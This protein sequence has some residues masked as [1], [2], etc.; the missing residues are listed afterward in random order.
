MKLDGYRIGE[1]LVHDQHVVICR[2]TR[3]DDDTRVT[4]KYCSREYPRP[5]EMRR[6]HFEFQLLEKLSDAAVVRAVALERTQVGPVLVLEDA[7][8]LGLAEAAGRTLPL[9]TF[10][11]L[12]KG[13]IAA[14]ESVHTRQVIHKNVQPSSLSF[15]ADS[16]SVKLLAFQFA[17]QLTHERQEV[18]AA[19]ALEGALPY[20]SPEQTGRMN[21]TL[22]YRSDYYSL[23]VTFYQLLTGGLPFD[24]PDAMSWV[25]C[26]ISRLAPLA[27]ERRR[28]VPVLLARIIDKLM[29]KDP[30]DRYQSCHGILGDL[31]TCEQN[32]ERISEFADMP[33][34]AHDVSNR[35]ALAQGLVGR[36]EEQ[37]LLMAAFEAARQGAARVLFVG[38]YSG[39]GKSSLIREVHRPIAANR[40]Y[41]AEGKFDQLQRGVPYAAVAQALRGLVQQLLGE[42]EASVVRWRE[43]VGETLSGV[44]GVLTPLVPEL[45]KL[46]GPQ[47]PAPAL[48]PLEAHH[49]FKSALSRFVQA[50]AGASHPVVL[51]LDDLQWADASTVDWLVELVATRE[52][53]HLLVLGA[54]RDN[55][56][57]AGH[58]L[59]NALAEMERRNPSRVARLGLGPLELTDTLALISRA[60]R[61]TPQECEPLARE[62]QRKTQGNPFFVTELLG[63]LQRAG[64][65]SV[66]PS[67]GR[68]HW[69]L[70]AVRTFAASDSAID[71]M[72]S[73]L[74]QLPAETNEVLRLAA[75]LGGEFT[76]Q[77]IASLVRCSVGEAAARLWPALQHDLIVPMG[78][79]YRLAHVVENSIQ[80]PAPE[81]RYRFQHDRVQ[82]AAYSL[83]PDVERA[84]LHLRIGRRLLAEQADPKQPTDLF[85][86]VS[87]LN[88]GRSLIQ[89]RAERKALADLNRR[90]GDRAFSGTA[91]DSA[92]DYHEFALGCLSPAE[93]A[94]QPAAHFEVAA[95]RVYSVLMAGD[96]QRA[97]EL[98]RELLGIAP[99]PTDR[100]MAY[101]TQCHV[102]VAQG[103]FAEAIAAVRAGLEPFGVP[104]PEN[105]EA[106]GQCIGQGIGT[107]QQH[108]ARVPIEDLPTLPMARDPEK[109]MAMKLLFAVVPPAIL[110]NPP[111]FILAELLMFDLAL[112]VGLVPESAKNFVDCGML[113]GGILGDF[114]RAYRLGKAAF[115]LLARCNA[116]SLSAGIHFVFAAY[117]S[118]WGA[119]HSEAVESFKLAQRLGI[120]TG[121]YAHLGFSEALRGRLLLFLGRPLDECEAE[122]ESL[123]ATLERVQAVV[124]QIGARCT[125]HGIQR[126]QN[127]SVDTREL[128]R[129]SLELKQAVTGNEPYTFQLGQM[130][131]V[132]EG[133]L[134]NWAAADEW[135]KFATPALQ[136]ASTLFATSEYQL[137]ECLITT[138]HRWPHANTA[139]RMSLLAD[140]NQR[141]ARLEDWAKR[142]PENFAVHYHLA[143][144]EIARVRAEP[145]ESVVGHYRRAIA[146]PG[147]A[148][149]HLRALASELYAR[150]WATHGEAGF[151]ASLLRE[152]WQLYR[153][154]GAAAVANHLQR[155]YSDVLG[156]RSL[157]PAMSRQSAGPSGRPLE[158]GN[159]ALDLSTVI[160]VNRL[161]SGEVRSDRLFSQLM[162][163]LTENAAAQHGC[164]VLPSSVDEWVV[165]ARCDTRRPEAEGTTS[166]L[167]EHEESACA[168]IVRY[169]ARSL[170][171]LV[172][173]DAR[174]HAQFCSDPGVIAR[175]VKS[176]LCMPIVHQSRLVAVL[177]LENNATTHAFTRDRVETL[178]LIAG[179]AAIS[180]TNALLYDNLEHAVTERTRELASKNREVRAMLDGMQRGVFTLDENLEV[181]PEYSRFLER[182]VGTP[183]IAGRTLRSLLFEGSDLSVNAQDD[184]EGA[185]R[186]S[187]GSGLA[188]AQSNA[189]HLVREYSR[190]RADG[191]EQ[192]LE[193][194]WNWI[195]D[196]RG[197]VARAL[198]T[199][200]DVT[201]LRRLRQA[202]ERAEKEAVMLA[203]I[204][205]AGVPAIRQYCEGAWK[206]LAD[207]AKAGAGEEG[208]R[209]AFRQLHTL[210]G[211]AR[212]LGLKSVVEAAHAAEETF[213]AGQVDPESRTVAVNA[214][215]L[216]IGE[217]KSTL[218]S[219]L[220]K[221]VNVE[222]A[223]WRSAVAAIES[224]LAVSNER[225]SYPVRALREVKQAV[226]RVNGVSLESLVRE[227]A[228]V[229]SSLAG[230][231]GK[232]VPNL[233]WQDDGFWIDST[234]TPVVRDALM[235]SFRNALD[236][237]LEP[238]EQRAAAGKPIAGTLTLRAERHGDELELR[239]RDDGR[240][241][242]LQALRE[243]TGRTSSSDEEVAQAVF[244]FGVSTAESVTECSGRGVG[245]DAVRDALRAR[246]GD[247][248]VA[249]TGVAKAGYRP[250]ELVF[251]LPRQA[252]LS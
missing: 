77:A 30:A 208:R 232:A 38:G 17:S 240:G 129:G 31:A 20:L 15:D 65:L 21:R 218:D 241:L 252:M 142:C 99:T 55:E 238:N 193:V 247:A 159:N 13:A 135:S 226:A 81:V 151:A 37:D 213:E 190:K 95:Q 174:E 42:P 136:G 162:S 196:E 189:E 6:L 27:S 148:F 228:S 250:F 158:G 155:T 192:H 138:Q 22:D 32:L 117:V 198:V 53:K 168:A 109:I 102:F 5:S 98:S 34:G 100:G 59:T 147:G 116:R 51:F 153:S 164:L 220:N 173:D 71:L 122:S 66:R 236:H 94:E 143:C 45:E 149:I 75:C 235:H 112:S 8:P 64:I 183:Q 91:F 229:F 4:L 134:G 12:A 139:T 154:W 161:I 78:V 63:A 137:F 25:H 177:Y 186:F 125:H 110:S 82:Q 119:P 219:K 166:Q 182:I 9:P 93:W 48:E 227:S 41:F 178:Q 221:I 237:G 172:L 160:K 128:E 14:L 210:K 202:A 171:T 46:L 35:L 249:F 115:T 80:P 86:V 201:E 216:T 124:P 73:H 60:L 130:Q 140:L 185:L 1:V 105:P 169:V 126:L 200:Q 251:S 222:D 96:R 36:R 107:M 114:D 121:D 62:V 146:A 28:E 88:R 242:A 54:Y 230:E 104:F 58:I 127:A 33:L 83:T 248:R 234:W 19:H 69:D 156:V 2:A 179:Q 195:P 132:I 194:A 233:E 118:V 76:L 90:A 24:A 133:L 207:V 131:V 191:N 3:V 72:L 203:E 7:A 61:R 212:V 157:A 50:V 245:L 123:L 29:A 223:R 106:V 70:D 74:G 56:V 243:R 11:A 239:L 224:V 47:P 87:Q 43:R 152:A 165:R 103:R 215:R 145:M 16:G 101:L 175:K 57:G 211:N 199:V 10:F 49:R 187:F 67:D 206:T 92:R 40:G 214:L 111:L 205:D 167:L 150:Y 188:V 217:Y 180:I 246:G 163:A 84:A 113:Q 39:I 244:D 204:L 89:D 225:P 97:T 44:A 184:T 23:G 141:T 85:G 176:V 170:D 144:A 197:K 108:L 52:L 209:A 18:R 26:H 68:W 181:Q 231:L 120:E 79:G